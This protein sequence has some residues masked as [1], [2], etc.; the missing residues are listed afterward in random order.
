MSNL[1]I[2]LQIIFIITVHFVFD[3]SMPTREERKEKHK[4]TK[5]C[6]RH[7]I[8]SLITFITISLFFIVANVTW[9]DMCELFL[10]YGCLSLFYASLHILQDVFV[11]RTFDK[12]VELKTSNI[13]N[14]KNKKLLEL[15]Q[16]QKD[17]IED[18]LITYTALDQLFH[19]ITIFLLIWWSLQ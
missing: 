1:E 3:W 10:L 6:W 12:V 15:T 11:W 8:N 2:I 5:N 4:N 19:L 13:L 17:E 9:F 16:Q 18:K 14:T 7:F